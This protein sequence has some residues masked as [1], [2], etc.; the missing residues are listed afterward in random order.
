VRDQSAQDDR[1]KLVSRLSSALG[2]I[3]F[4]G[5]P[6]LTVMAQTLFKEATKEGK[7]ETQSNLG[8]FLFAARKDLG[9]TVSWPIQREIDRVLRRLDED[10]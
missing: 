1:E 10:N 7:D 9:Y 6:E 8:A 5:S 3:A 4:V 2:L